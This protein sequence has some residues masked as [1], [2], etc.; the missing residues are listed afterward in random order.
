MQVWVVTAVQECGYDAIKGI[1]T[2]FEAAAEEMIYHL[3]EYYSKD[4]ADKL[5]EYDCEEDLERDII[6][7]LNDFDYIMTIFKK[8]CY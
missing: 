2:C 6:C 1:F 8:T 4:W 7:G 3:K 5:T